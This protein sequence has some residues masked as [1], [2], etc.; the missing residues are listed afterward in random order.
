MRTS[1]NKHLLLLRSNASKERDNLGDILRSGNARAAGGTGGVRRRVGL[2]VL[3]RRD[4][5]EIIA[6]ANDDS[7]EHSPANFEWG[8]GGGF[9]RPNALKPTS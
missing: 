6:N 9:Q 4:N 8:G 2:F 5:L 7:D 3:K 1:D